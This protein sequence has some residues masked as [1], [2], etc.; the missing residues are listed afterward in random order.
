MLEIGSRKS[1]VEIR[2]TIF[3]KCSQIMAYADDVIFMERR[4]HDFEEVFTPL[5]E[6]TKNMV[7]EIN[8]KRENL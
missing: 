3:D 5:V 7:L 4:L 2:G 6:Q 8:E 1:N